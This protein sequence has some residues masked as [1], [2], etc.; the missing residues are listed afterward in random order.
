MI[1]NR[2]FGALVIIVHL[3]NF[4]LLLISP[5]MATLVPMLMMPLLALSNAVKC[6]TKVIIIAHNLGD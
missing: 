2:R 4:P 3:H 6:I 1:Q 5:V